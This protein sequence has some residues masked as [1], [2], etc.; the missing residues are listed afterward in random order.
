VARTVF[1]HPKHQTTFGVPESKSLATIFGSTE[2]QRR[3]VGQFFAAEVPHP[4]D[5]LA[6]RMP[7]L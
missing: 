5:I 3:T 2:N 7:K 4:A 1:G 6:G